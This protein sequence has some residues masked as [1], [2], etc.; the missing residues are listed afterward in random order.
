MQFYLGHHLPPLIV[1]E[2]HL[3]RVPDDKYPVYELLGSIKAL[4]SV[5]YTV[6]DNRIG[7]GGCE[8]GLL[9]I[10]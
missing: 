4:L 9:R 5:G 3:G 6:Y 10:K 7:D 2:L 1:Y 8:L